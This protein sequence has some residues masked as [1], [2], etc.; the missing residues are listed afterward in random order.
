ME[1]GTIY[2]RLLGMIAISLNGAIGLDGF[3]AIGVVGLR[4]LL[5]NGFFARVGFANVCREVCTIG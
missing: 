5:R 4:N 2:L 1:E 3:L